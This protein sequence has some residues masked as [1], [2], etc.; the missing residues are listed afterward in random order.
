MRGRRQRGRSGAV[1]GQHDGS[2]RPHG[3]RRGRP[4]RWLV[5]GS[6]PVPQMVQYTLHNN[7]HTEAHI[8]GNEFGCCVMLC[9][10]TGAMYWQGS[11]QVALQSLRCRVC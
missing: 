4:L 1:H 7:K 8:Q 11:Q 9:T 5:A 3:H 10:V 2:A 6:H